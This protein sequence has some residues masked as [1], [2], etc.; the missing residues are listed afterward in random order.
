MTTTHETLIDLFKD[1]EIYVRFISDMRDASIQVFAHVGDHGEDC[2]AVQ[3]NEPSDA[4]SKTCIWLDYHADINWGGPGVKFVMF[5]LLRW[6]PP[7]R[8]YVN[9]RMLENRDCVPT[10]IIHEYVIMLL[11]EDRKTVEGVGRALDEVIE[12]TTQ[13]RL[14]PAFAPVLEYR[15]GYDFRGE[16]LLGLLSCVKE[17]PEALPIFEEI[18]R[19]ARKHCE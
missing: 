14:N 17:E 19:E 18:A 5:P 4:A 8:D 3:V 9:R 7:V 2:P 6:D 12:F 11:D 13:L 1:N 10:D 15:D 16:A